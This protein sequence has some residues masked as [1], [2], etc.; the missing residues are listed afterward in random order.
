[1]KTGKPECH[2]NF[3]AD[4]SNQDDKNANNEEK[5]IVH[6]YANGFLDEILV[7]N[8]VPDEVPCAEDNP[9][10]SSMSTASTTSLNTTSTSIMNGLWSETNRRH[11][12]DTIDRLSK[13]FDR[14]HSLHSINEYANSY[15][16]R[17]L[18]SS[19]R[20]TNNSNTNGFSTGPRKKLI[21]NKSSSIGYALNV[22]S[23]RNFVPE[24]TVKQYAKVT[25]KN[26]LKSKASKNQARY[27][28]DCLKRSSYMNDFIESIL[29][30][31]YV[32]TAQYCRYHV[33]SDNEIFSIDYKRMFNTLVLDRN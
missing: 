8:G 26:I 29:N 16:R 10:N 3:I 21:I 33:K 11:S 27:S 7:G 15:K 23:S 4:A 25:L 12:I 20:K 30:D 14:R 19:N 2:A 1:M 18:S 13:Q 6:K 32:E 24:N 22:D 31:A 5:S 17:N 28:I 9:L